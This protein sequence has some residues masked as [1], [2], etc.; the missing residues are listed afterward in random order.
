ME[1]KYGSH[2]RMGRAPNADSRDNRVLTT[3]A[4]G[5]LVHG[6]AQA[7]WTPSL[8]HRGRFVA[9]SIGYCYQRPLSVP[10][11]W[12]N[13][14]S[15]AAPPRGVTCACGTAPPP[16]RDYLLLASSDDPAAH[17]VTQPGAAGRRKGQVIFMDLGASTWLTGLGGS[18]QGYFSGAYADRGLRFD[19]SGSPPPR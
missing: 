17:A 8:L 5:G 6:R 12:K 13:R 1:E 3:A 11:A 15:S 18:S 10:S 16:C 19:R 7:S 4:G 14:H 2:R 9:I